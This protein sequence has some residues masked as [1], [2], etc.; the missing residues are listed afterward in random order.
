MGQGNSANNTKD[1]RGDNTLH[2]P[3]TDRNRGPG[4]DQASLLLGRNSDKRDSNEQL[5][6][7][8]RDI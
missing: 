1:G 6:T 8:G 2:R 4:W 3:T 7:R 5:A